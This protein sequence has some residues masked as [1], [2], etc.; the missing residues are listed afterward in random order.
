MGMVG[1]GVTSIVAVGPGVSVATI[2]V[3]AADGAAKVGVAV[4]VTVKLHA[5][6]AATKT[7]IQ[8]GNPLLSI[9]PPPRT[10]HA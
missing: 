4:P 2:W 9:K 7:P 6:D 10:I 5:K 8:M 3:G 1:E